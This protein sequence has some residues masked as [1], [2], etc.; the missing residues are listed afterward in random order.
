MC[1]P[2]FDSNTDRYLCTMVW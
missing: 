2:W 1:V